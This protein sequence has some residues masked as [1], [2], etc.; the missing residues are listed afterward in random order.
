MKA[1]ILIV[2]D[3][4]QFLHSLKQFLEMNEFQ[5][6]EKANPYQALEMFKNEDFDCVL[7]D[8]KM[9]GMDG[10]SLME[11]MIKEREDIPFVLISGE[12][13]IPKAIQAI[14]QG[15]YDFI[16][17][18]VD[19]ERLLITLKNAI[20]KRNL[21]LERESLRAQID[22]TF[23]FIGKSKAIQDILTKIETIARSNAKVLITGESGTGKELIARMIHNKSLRAKR[24]F[25]KVNCAA[26]PETLLESELFGYKKGAFTGA[27][28]D[29]RGKFLVAD[30]GTLFLDEIGDM[31]Y[32][33]QAKLLRVLENNE[34]EVLGGSLP[35]KVD[36]RLIAAT[37][38][39]LQSLIQTGQF[40][41]DLYHRLNVIHI[42]IPPLREHVEDIPLLV[43][44]FFKTFS[45]IYNKQI[46]GIND[47]AMDL[48]MR[49]PWPGNVREL[50]N[51][52][53][54]LV[55]FTVNDR[56]TLSE[57]EEA[58]GMKSVEE[59]EEPQHESES[60][61][62]LKEALEDYEKRYIEET[63]KKYNW[64]IN[65]TARELKISRS[66]L[67]KKMRRFGIDK[68]QPGRSSSRI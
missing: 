67:F 36:V 57:V 8:L 1:K 64:K 22:E 62:S 68:I 40:R 37:N 50:R 24:P 21:L 15:A 23:L 45:Q 63:L 34:V 28:R 2:D 31:P 30:Q 10:L 59:A 35:E 39:D 47:E 53:E 32:T 19:A 44:H 46:S 12:G 52:I 13:T 20:E 43:D 49:H 7:L 51:L 56:I 14:K 27:T 48:L 42:H 41:E 4:P 58:L 65:K 29:F 60:V 55:I 66:T 26:I 18:P 11:N 38:K 17:K 6:Q 3:D 61:D 5:V 25:V 54:K 16:E 9:P 33:L